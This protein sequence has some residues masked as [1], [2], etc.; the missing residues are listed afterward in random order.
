MPTV[1][2]TDVLSARQVLADHLPPTPMWSY[3]VLDAEVGARLHV[4][5]EN[6]QPTG[7]F[8]VRGGLNLLAGMPAEHRAR[9]VIA[10]STGNHAQSIAYAAARFDA[11]CVIVMPEDPNPAKVDAIRALGATVE[12]HGPTM[13]E[14]A[15]HAAGL[16]SDSGM[17]LISAGDEPALVAGV[18]TT[19]LEIIEEVPDLDVLFVPVGGG[20]GA[21]GACVVTA[22]LAPRCRVIAVQSERAPAAHD[23]WRSGTSVT[24]PIRTVAEGLAT[25][26]GFALTQGIM[27][28]DLTDFTLVTDAQ[29]RTAQRLMLTHAHTLAEGAGATALAGFLAQGARFAGARVAVAC[30]G[31][32]ASPAEVVDVLAADPVEAAPAPA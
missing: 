24:R 2:I 11:P 13:T 21:A 30:S 22:A 19:Y 16:A 20:T 9:G 17:R 31:G 25:G 7:A 8:K 27:R 10:Y 3:P 28:A 29:I 15:A 12:L 1:T 26:T 5:H 32:N 4:K 6:V 14:A 23:C 18:A